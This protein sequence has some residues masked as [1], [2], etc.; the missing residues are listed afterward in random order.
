[1]LVESGVISREQ[2]AEALEYQKIWGHRL[3]TALVA[4]RFITETELTEVLAREL[5]VEMA[6]PLAMHI[7]QEVLML[8][9][10]QVAAAND[11]IPISLEER[12]GM[13]RLVVAMVDPLNYDAI[14]KVRHASRMNVLPVIATMSS[15]AKAI[16]DR[17]GVVAAAEKAPAFADSEMVIVHKGGDEVT[18]GPEGLRNRSQRPAPPK[19]DP[20]ADTDLFGDARAR[21]VPMMVDP[22]RLPPP[23]PGAP[24]YPP[25]DPAMAR[26]QGYPTL[27]AH[28]APPAGA[29]Y[30]TYPPPGYG[31]PA[32]IPA[33]AP[34]ARAVPAASAKTPGAVSVA[35]MEEISRFSP[36]DLL[37]GVIRL[38]IRNGTF[39][40]EELLEELRRRG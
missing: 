3:G 33:P 40:G 37:L 19:A 5:R 10:R 9:P 16:R 15:V 22:A 36:R 32:P 35:V 1:M 20:F 31:V 34:A 29:A 2:L 30:P 18:L 8:V 13:K 11:V 28:P 24:A 25:I 23:Y 21:E 38:L 7:P 26:S 12:G 4:K 14:S 39:A 17:Y 27:G 6:D